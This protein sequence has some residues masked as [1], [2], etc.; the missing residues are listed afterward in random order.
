MS[1]PSMTIHGSTTPPG[2]PAPS[3]LP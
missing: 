2:P 1:C 3:P